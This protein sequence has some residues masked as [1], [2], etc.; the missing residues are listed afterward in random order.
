MFVVIGNPPYN[1]GQIN[2]NDN[3]K[4]RKYKTMDK[5]VRETYSQRLKGDSIKTHSTRPLCEGDSVGI[6]PDRG[7]RRCCLCDEQQLSR[8]CCL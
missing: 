8:C 3:N 1:A 7:W 4:N 5:Q 6:G 2:E